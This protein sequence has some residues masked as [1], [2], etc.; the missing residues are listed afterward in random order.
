MKVYAISDLHLASRVDK[1]MDV[2]G[3]HWE[4]YWDKIREDWHGKVTEEDVVLIPG[5]ISWAMN[6]EEAEQDLQE[7]CQLPG[8]KVMIKGNHDYWHASISKTRARLFNNTYFLQNDALRIG[9]YTFAGTR[10]WV[11]RESD[12]FDMQDEKIYMRECM[13]LNLSLDAAK[14]L[15][16]EIIGLSHYPPYS[17]ARGASEVTDL[18][19]SYGVKN[20]VYGHLHGPQ[21]KEQMERIITINEVNYH[22][23][24]CDYLGFSLEKIK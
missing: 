2:F 23:T 12:G 18:Y 24:S 15:G 6:Y 21:L 14:K 20:V 1:P 13:R 10:G 4:N 7:I 3:Q 19:A 5:D 22:L 9:D 8:H 16:G 11:Q 17:A